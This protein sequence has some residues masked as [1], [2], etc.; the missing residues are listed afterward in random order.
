MRRLLPSPL[1]SLALFALWLALNRSMAPGHL[2]MAALLAILMPVL[3]APLRPYRV[4]IRHPLVLA[5][6][7]LTVGHDVV[8]SN[9]NVGWGVLRSY[10]RMP[11]GAF[12]RIPLELRSPVALAALSTITTVIPG[13]VWCELMLDRS[14]LLLHVFDLD[15]EA[16]FIAHFKARYERPLKEIFE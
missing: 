3:V 9:L 16:E 13:T 7:I 4:R 8:L 6:L 14:S 2:I 1:L 15:D 11:R 10:R 5:R 12:V